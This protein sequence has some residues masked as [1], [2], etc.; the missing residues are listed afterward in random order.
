[1]EPDM[2]RILA[3]AALASLLA[4][5]PVRSAGQDPEPPRFGRLPTIKEIM[6]E[7]HKCRTAYII[8]IRKEMAKE[9][10][11][12]IDWA[13]VTEKSRGLVNAGKMLAMNTPPKGTR[14]G[15]DKRTTVYVANAVLMLDAAERQS[16]DDVAYHVKKLGGMCAGCHREHR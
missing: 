14:E 16:K 13:L 11:E 8:E 2:K 10:P 4:L 1:M 15:W 6:Q 3:V 9:R 7:S 5:L 12:E